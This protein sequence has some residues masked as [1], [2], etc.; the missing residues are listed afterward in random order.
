MAQG[1]QNSTFEIETM[2][3]KLQDLANKSVNAMANG[4]NKTDVIVKQ[5]AEVA[6]SF[7]EI[8]NAVGNVSEMMQQ[9]AFAAE[10]QNVTVS[11]R[12]SQAE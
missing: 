8:N 9:T 3:V 10:E 4:R 6:T 1:T 7:E 11:D 2:I 5:T 12:S